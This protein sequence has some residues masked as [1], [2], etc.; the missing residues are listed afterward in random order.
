MTLAYL[1]LSSSLH[2]PQPENTSS[3]RSFPLPE[4][5]PGLVEGVLR[6]YES[7]S[8]F[9]MI[10][11]FLRLFHPGW[12]LNDEHCILDDVPTEECQDWWGEDLRGLTL[13]TP[14][15]TYFWISILAL[16]APHSYSILM[17]SRLWVPSLITGN[18]LFSMPSTDCLTVLKRVPEMNVA[19]Q[20][21][22]TQQFVY[23]V[24]SSVKD[25]GYWV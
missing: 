9:D 18:V 8:D 14:C 15:I 20:L 24:L 7:S 6:S 19:G 21:S 13:W 22:F 25:D 10:E 1:P 2:H 11:R 17:D 16:C 5:H 3:P 23:R 4:L 12:V